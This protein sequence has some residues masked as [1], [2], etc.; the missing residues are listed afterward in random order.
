MTRPLLLHP[1]DWNPAYR[2]IPTRFPA[3]DLFESVAD[4]KDWEALLALESRTNDR[5]RDEVGDIS[6]IP[7]KERAMGP[8]CTFRGRAKITCAVQVILL[9]PLMSVRHPND[10]VILAQRLINAAFT[11]PHPGRF[12]TAQR[13]AFYAADREAVAV[14]EVAYHAALNAGFDQ[15]EPLDLEYQVLKV[16]VNGNF[17][18]LRQLGP[19]SPITHS[20]EY[21]R[22][23]ELSLSLR[24]EGSKGVVYHSVRVSEGDCIA[25]FTPTVLK[26]C[27]HARYLTFRWDGKRIV[28]IVETRPYRL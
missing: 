5:I 10:Q 4:P 21:G 9:R 8:G 27:R 12:S 18:D 2:I 20:V 28:S 22:S 3:I 15:L 14:A 19:R 7:P 23:Q 25:A 26:H 16:R 6:L 13:G 11:H 24:Q 17:H 1:L